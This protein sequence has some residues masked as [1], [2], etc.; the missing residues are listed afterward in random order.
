MEGEILKGV[1]WCPLRNY[2]LESLCFEGLGLRETGRYLS[3]GHSGVPRF[4]KA[5]NCH[6]RAAGA[7]FG[8]NSVAILALEVLLES[9]MLDSVLG[10]QASAGALVMCQPSLMLAFL[11]TMKKNLVLRALGGQ[12]KTE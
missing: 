4:S 1:S 6:H 9:V 7:D 10:P 2:H 12:A 11:P 5:T 8:M 3:C